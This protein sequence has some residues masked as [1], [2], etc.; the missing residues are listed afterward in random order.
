MSILVL[1]YEDRDYG[2]DVV[3]VEPGTESIPQGRGSDEITSVKMTEDEAILLFKKRDH[4]GGVFYLR[5]ENEISHLGRPSQGGRRGWGNDISSIRMSPFHVRVN[6]VV[7]LDGDGSMPA[8]FTDVTTARSRIDSCIWAANQFFEDQ[9]A[10]VKLHL[11]RFRCERF[12]RKFDVK[13]NQRLR[14]PGRFKETG[15][16]NVFWVNSISGASGYAMY[17]WWGNVGVMSTGSSSNP[18]QG[19]RLRS[20]QRTFIHEIGHYF[21]LRHENGSP[22]NIMAQ[23]SV[24]DPWRDSELTDD[25]IERMHKKLASGTGRRSVRNERDWW[26]G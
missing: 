1:L 3:S 19:R 17:P 14:M 10:L 7:I 26:N 13:T 5:G 15:R 4:R 16:I 2:G 11:G 25:Q 21:S 9:K 24:G 12:K 22:E 6:C 18:G 23:S 8:G 20:L